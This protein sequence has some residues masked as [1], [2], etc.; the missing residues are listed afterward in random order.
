LIPEEEP[1]PLSC[2]PSEKV[3]GFSGKVS[4]ELL[5]KMALGYNTPL[6]IMCV[7]S[8]GQLPPL[9]MDLIANHDKK[10]EGLG[11]KSSTKGMRELNRLF[12]SV[13]Y[14]AHSGNS[15]SGR[16]KGRVH[17]SLI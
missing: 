2:C 13:N 4:L 12:C 8:K 11:S 14:D 7:G 10:E 3:R 5:L 1:S 15:S 17:G 6:G 16:R 9:F